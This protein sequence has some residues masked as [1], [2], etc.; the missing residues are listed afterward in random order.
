MPIHSV[1]VGMPEPCSVTGTMVCEG[2]VGIFFRVKRQ[3]RE[4]RYTRDGHREP[5]FYGLVPK[6]VLQ[7]MAL[8][9]RDIGHMR[10]S[11]LIHLDRSELAGSR[12]IDDLDMPFG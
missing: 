3:R 7:R 11:L 6:R 8:S 1:P 10:I 5:T 2:D 12:I 4:A 9:V